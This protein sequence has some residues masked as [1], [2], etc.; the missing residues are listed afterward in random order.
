MSPYKRELG[1]RKNRAA[2]FRDREIHLLVGIFEY[3]HANDLSAEII[4]VAFSVV[5]C[6]SKQHQQAFVD[7]SDN[8]APDLHRSTTYSLDDSSHNTNDNSDKL[9][10]GN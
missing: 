9:I 4:R 10:I 7:L 5:L 8:F 1:D 6:D 3:A 2:D